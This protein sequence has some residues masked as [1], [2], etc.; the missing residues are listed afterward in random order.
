VQDAA[1]QLMG[2]LRESFP[3]YKDLLRNGLLV[4]KQI[5]S[6]VQPSS[7]PDVFAFVCLVRAMDETMKAAGHDTGYFVTTKEIRRWE[8]IWDIPKTISKYFTFL[9]DLDDRLNRPFSSHLC[10]LKN[11]FRGQVFSELG[12]SLWPDWCVGASVIDDGIYHASE[13]RSDEDLF[14]PLLERILAQTARGE[15]FNFSSW[16][17]KPRGADSRSPN[18]TPGG[19]N[20]HSSRPHDP[21]EEN[22]PALSS[23][24]SL[25]NRNLDSKDLREW[26]LVII[27]IMFVACKFTSFRIPRS[28]R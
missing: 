5:L 26:T 14:L 23:S 17:Q 21:G 12:R 15:A 19:S 25:E 18:P 13:T 28:L 27:A 24:S 11:R 3:C 2:E 10:L 16:L 7:L 8:R 4:F 22:E 20:G 1:G 9:Y 6:G